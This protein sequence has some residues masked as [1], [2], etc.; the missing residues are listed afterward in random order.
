MKV[1]DSWTVNCVSEEQLDIAVSEIAYTQGMNSRSTLNPTWH[2][3]VSFADDEL[4]GE[5]LR[6]IEK[7][8]CDGLGMSEHQRICA[9]HNDTSNLHFHIALNRVHP[10]TG[11]FIN[12]AWS[13]YA[14]QDIGIAIEK[15][16]HLQPTITESIQKDPSQKQTGLSW[17]QV[18]GMESFLSWTK[19]RCSETIANAQSWESLHTELAKQGILLKKRGNG[20]ALATSDDKH[21]VKA[22]SVNREFSLKRLESRLGEFQSGKQASVGESRYT[23]KP[24]LM[25]SQL[26]NK[27]QKSIKDTQAVY[28]SKLDQLRQDRDDSRV[29]IKWR[30]RELRLQNR[31]ST[32]RNRLKKA[33]NSVLKYS[34]VSE[35]DAVSTLFV[36]EVAAAKKQ[37]PF[38]S[39]Y[40]FLQ[41]EA[42]QGSD[43]A[44]RLLQKMATPNYHHPSIFGHRRNGVSEHYGYHINRYGDVEYKLDGGKTIIDTGKS[45]L[46]DRGLSESVVD[47]GLALSL[48][49][50]G[51]NIKVD[52]EK[53]KA[54]IEE[55]I[56]SGKMSITLNNVSYIRGELSGQGKER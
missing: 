6:E 40:E 30:Y 46:L 29:D 52:N 11:K 21:A 28:H 35:L 45:I 56:Q 27:Y 26:W 23:R 13:K 47:T 5:T 14:M 32:K 12:P 42:G 15:K 55:R 38:I 8:I 10:E 9:V 39:W 4:S 44:K 24:R 20:L 17:E 7:E 36:N 18:S 1:E 53:L 22:S 48:A 31:Q 54:M 43:D 2:L 3:I 34:R 25:N 50:F 33:K 19:G 49:S 41:V 51:N 16:Y 37:H